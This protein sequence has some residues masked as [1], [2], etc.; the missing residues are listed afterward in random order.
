M[1]T[2][3]TP[4]WMFLVAAATAGLGGGNFASSMANISYF[5]PERHKGSALGINAA[6]GNIGVAVV[7][8]VVPVV[9]GI[10]CRR[11]QPPALLRTSR[12]CT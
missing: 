10:G 1:T 12:W 5:Y 6:G 8:I 2:P 11:A 3:G 4:Y 7:Q 9:I